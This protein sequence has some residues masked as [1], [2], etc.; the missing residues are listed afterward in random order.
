[1]TDEITGDPSV[2]KMIVVYHIRVWVDQ[3]RPLVYFR[4]YLKVKSEH[5]AQYTFLFVQGLGLQ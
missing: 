4:F 2:L 3:I 5:L 1:M